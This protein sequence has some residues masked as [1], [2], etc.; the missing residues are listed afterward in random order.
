MQEQFIL[1]VIADNQAG[2]LKSFKPFSRRGY[3]I[4]SLTVSATDTPSTQE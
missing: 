2:V 3:N 1:S 4:D